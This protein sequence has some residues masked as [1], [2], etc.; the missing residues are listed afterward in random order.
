VAERGG[1]TAIC[2]LAFPSGVEETAWGSWICPIVTL[3]AQIKK[4]I[5]KNQKTLS[6]SLAQP[7]K[8]VVQWSNRAGKTPEEP[9]SFNSVQQS[10]RHLSPILRSQS[11]MNSDFSLILALFVISRDI[12]LV[13]SIQNKQKQPDFGIPQIRALQW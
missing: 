3:Y 9:R 8:S 4:K 7:H 1:Y 11:V 13:G 2:T 5:K 12:A 6:S 10:G